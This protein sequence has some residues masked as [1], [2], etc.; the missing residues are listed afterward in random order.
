MANEMTYNGMTK[1]RI[2]EF[3]GSSIEIHEKDI[4]L[5]HEKRIEQINERVQKFE[6]ER[7]ALLEEIKA[8]MTVKGQQL[9]TLE[10]LIQMMYKE[11][12]ASEGI[13]LELRGEFEGKESA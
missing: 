8:F 6:E 5:F 4:A 1:Q 12:G 2:K 9:L 13:M 11:Y 3:F 7:D 10:Q